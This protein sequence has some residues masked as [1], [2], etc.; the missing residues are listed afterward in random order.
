MDMQVYSYIKGRAKKVMQILV[1]KDML[2]S[3][4][5]A[6]KKEIQIGRNLFCLTLYSLF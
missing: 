5:I 1:G 6:G 2:V 3:Q 4:W